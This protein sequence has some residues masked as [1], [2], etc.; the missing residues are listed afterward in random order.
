MDS[1]YDFIV[2]PL[3]NRYNNTKKVGDK[4]L[5]LNTEVFNHQFV[6]REAEVVGLPRVNSYNI[7]I[8]DI[9]TV[10]H[11]VFRRW[12]NIRGEEKN[13]RNY[14]SEDLYAL[15]V[16]QIFLR[17]RDGEYEP[18]GDFCFVQPIK[19]TDELSL[20][21]ERPLVGVVTYSS[22]EGFA[23][24]DLVGFKPDSE[25]EFIIDGKRLYRVY[26]NFIT[27]KYEY[28]GDEEEYNPSWA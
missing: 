12:H 6:N 14:I 9:L 7:K 18:V 4:D 5:I 13:S 28:K 15:D 11:N 19:S 16:E 27:I 17:K 23:N 10:H 25:Y 22:N 24:G 1:V 26:N 8:G 21:V 20:D 3:G 2:K